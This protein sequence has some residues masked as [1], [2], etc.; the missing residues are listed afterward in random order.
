VKRKKIS[1]TDYAEHSEWLR[2][3]IGSYTSRN[4]LLSY[5]SF[6]KLSAVPYKTLLRFCQNVAVTKYKTFCAI[7]TFLET[8]AENGRH[9]FDDNKFEFTQINYQDHVEEIREKLTDVMGIKRLCPADLVEEIGVD[10]ETIGSFCKKKRT[11]TLATFLKI[12]NYLNNA[13]NHEV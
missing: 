6:S 10:D 9:V 4:N 11:I 5:N 12:N 7:L 1:F 2:N 8:E 3:E 13:S